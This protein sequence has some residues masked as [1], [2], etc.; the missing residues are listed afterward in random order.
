MPSHD[1]PQRRFQPPQAF[2]RIEDGGGG[3]R[4][5]RRAGHG[6][7]A[8]GSGAVLVG[9]GDKCFGDGEAAGEVCGGLSDGGALGHGVGPSLTAPYCAFHRSLNS[10]ASSSVSSR[11]VMSP[12][13]ASSSSASAVKC[14]AMI[15]SV[16][17]S[18]A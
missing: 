10:A 5:P 18:S 15:R 6:G 11:T 1:Q 8:Y 7:A 17:V 3:L 13:G 4:V 12:S 9:E 2:V 14:F 16:L